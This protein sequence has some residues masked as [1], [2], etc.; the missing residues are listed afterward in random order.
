MLPSPALTGEVRCENVVPVVVLEDGGALC[1]VARLQVG[2][3]RCSTMG[4]ATHFAAAADPT[5]PDCRRTMEQVLPVVASQSG[6]SMDTAMVCMHPIES[7]GT[8]QSAPAS[9]FSTTST[10]QHCD[11][12]LPPTCTGHERM[13]KARCVSGSTYNV[14]SYDVFWSGKKECTHWYGPAG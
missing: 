7:D 10:A 4:T 13:R 1:T 5:P 11:R 3:S 14:I 12:T 8:V 6:R 2:G 9:S